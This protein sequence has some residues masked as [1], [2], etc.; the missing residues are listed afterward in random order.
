MTERMTTKQAAEYIGVCLRTMR[1]Y[2]AEGIIPCTKPMGR[3]YFK[4]SDLDA[5]MNN[6]L[7]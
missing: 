2:I 5:F 3:W 1:T 7:R 6:E 4:R